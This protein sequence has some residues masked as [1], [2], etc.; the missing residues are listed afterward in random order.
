MNLEAITTDTSFGKAQGILNGYIRDLEIA[1]GQP[2]RVGRYQLE[3]ELLIFRQRIDGPAVGTGQ[4]F[5]AAQ[6]RLDQ[7]ICV[8]FR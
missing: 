3:F 5:G 4:T 2:Q 7:P 6:D 1:H 8:P